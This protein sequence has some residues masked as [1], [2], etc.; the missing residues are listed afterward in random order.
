LE[1]AIRCLRAG[2]FC[3][4]NTAIEG[5]LAEGLLACGQISEAQETVEGAIGRCRAS[6]EAWCLAELLRI[7]AM[8][9]AGA[10][11]F[12]EAD[13]VLAG[14]LKI[15]RAQGALA[16]ELRLAS[17][18]AENE[19]SVGARETL[20]GVLDRVQ[21]GFGTNDYLRAVARLGR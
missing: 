11:R 17:T 9:L 7:R 1:H 19:D 8:T 10:S 15:A 5:V 12:T 21:E 3:I 18:L 13:G 14:G 20:R 4:Y 2:P 6:G 16:W